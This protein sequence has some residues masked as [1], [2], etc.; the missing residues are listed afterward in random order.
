MGLDG[1][2]LEPVVAAGTLDG[3]DDVVGRAEQQ[4]GV[5]YG[6]RCRR[7]STGGCRGR[8]AH[9]EADG[10][11][12]IVADL[13]DAAVELVVDDF[14]LRGGSVGDGLDDVACEGVDDSVFTG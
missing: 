8:A 4:V 11:Q 5:A 10:R 2:A 12:G 13:L 1:P 9:G 3:V 14:A 6:C 7:S